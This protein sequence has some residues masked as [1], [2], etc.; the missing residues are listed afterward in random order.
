MWDLVV[1][2]FAIQFVAFCIAA[3]LQTEKFYDGVGS[4]TF[5]L[6]IVLNYLRSSQSQ[7]SFLLTVMVTMWAIRLGI[8]LAN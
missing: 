1:L 6:L 7:R 2:D 4:G 8:F 5:L 3:A